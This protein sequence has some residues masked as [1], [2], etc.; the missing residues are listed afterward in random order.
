M[1]A[2]QHRLVLARPR[3]R[4]AR[5]P[6]RPSQSTG[7]YRLPHDVQDRLV[8]SLAPFRN[9]DAAFAL[10]KFLARF[11]SAPGRVVGSFPIDRRALADHPDLGLTEARVRGA[12]RVLEEIGFLARALTSGS[13]Y[14]ATP[15]G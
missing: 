9:R 1:L 8:A 3:T 11:W 14:K 2:V 15:D 7:T 12:I 6:F 10:A 5:R 4:S 13:D